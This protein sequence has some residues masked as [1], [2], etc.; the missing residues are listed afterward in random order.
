M[1]SSKIPSSARDGWRICTVVVCLAL[2]IASAVQAAPT[3]EATFETYCNQCHGEAAMAGVSLTKLTAQVSMGPSFQQW[4]KV[5]EVLE[6]GR[7]PPEGLPQPSA[8]ERNAAAK[9]VQDGLDDYARKHGGDPGRVTVRRLTS[10]EYS[11]VIE[12]L[13]GVDIDLG[14]GFVSD[15]VGGEGFTNYGDVQFMQD[16]A[17]ERYLEA[18]KLVAE[19]A[20]I[21]SGPLDF[22]RDAGM[23][24]FELSA[25]HRIHDIYREHGFRAVAAE[26]GRAFGLERYGK[27][28]YAAWQ[29][30]NRDALNLG[31]ITLDEL[32]AREDLSPRFMEHVWRVLQTPDPSYPTSEVVAQWR[33]LAAPGSKSEEELRAACAEIQGFVINWPRW[34]FGAGALAAGGAGDERALVITDASLEAKTADKLT[35]L[36]RVRERGQA[37]VFLSAAPTDPNS[38]EE[39]VIHWKNVTVRMGRDEPGKPLREMLDEKTITALGFGRGVDG[40]VGPDDFVTVGTTEIDFSLNLPNDARFVAVNMEVELDKERSGDSIT[41]VL[42]SENE[43]GTGRPAWVLLGDSET[44]AFAAWKK[45]VLAYAARFPQ[46]S[47][48]EPTP[49][50]RDPIPAPFNNVYN[51]PERDRFHQRVKYYRDDEFLVDKMLDDETRVALEQAWTD[52]MASFEYHDAFLDFVEDKFEL[53]LDG[54]GI[55]ELTDADIAALAE[56]PRQYVRAL[57]DEYTEMV[58]TH[59]AAEPGHLKDA[60]DFA[61]RAWRRPLRQTEKQEL[62]SFYARTRQNFELDHRRAMRTLIA[63]ILVA[64]DFLYRLEKPEQ[65]SGAGPLDDWEVANRLSFFLWSSVPDAELRRAAAAGELTDPAQV[66]AQ[67]KRMLADPKARRIATEFFGQWLGFYRFDEYRGVDAKRFPEFTDE[68]KASMYDE[69]VSFFQHLVQK[70]R[71]IREMITADYTFL[72]KALAEHYGIEKEIEST[73]SVELV[74]GADELNRG[75]MLRLGAVLT[76]TSAPLRT[77]PVKRGDW[78]LRRVVGTPT[79]PPPPNVDLLPA[80]DKAFGGKTVRQQLEEHSRNPTCAS[81]HT[82]IDPLGF[83]LEHYDSIGR[84][85]ENYSEGQP[86]DDNSKLQ[87]NTEIAGMDG[88]IDYLDS[89]E[90]QVLDTF[91]KKLLGYALGRTMLASDLPLLN[92]MIAAGGDATFAEL[93][94]KIAASKQFLER[95]GINEDPPGEVSTGAAAEE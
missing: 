91:S 11:Y 1:H 60:L 66:A 4:Q 80:D 76:A 3:A 5:I 2:A 43:E 17:F 33:A 30:E 51:Q 93:A 6:S 59:K 24:G 45:D 57:K 62:R 70:D 78:L 87:D 12:D 23:S 84:W 65:L 95:R 46:T 26:G 40:V 37:K 69:A 38:T 35:L 14:A 85:R 9:W 16:A 90:E 68:V 49:S 86:I 88:L 74:E 82:R 25:I 71:P 75:G 48:G 15:S 50:D 92:D 81:C 55:A 73:N 83:P 13:T 20:V 28:F 36:I 63:R 56:E 8:E 52:L 41:R 44:E 89:Q 7:M 58:K 21:G 79:P 32:A 77:S 94:A 22:Y 29:Y 19:H 42:V 39:A 67:T 10:G 34:L 47:H 54:K 27:A 53:E 64:P 72:N 31:A 61:E 18:A